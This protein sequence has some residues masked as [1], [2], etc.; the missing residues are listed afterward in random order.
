VP[1]AVGGCGKLQ[2]PSAFFPIVRLVFARERPNLFID[3]LDAPET[4]P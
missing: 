2:D 4:Q 1:I 3:Y